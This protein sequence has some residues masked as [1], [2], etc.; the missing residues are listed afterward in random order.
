MSARVLVNATTLVVGGGIQVGASFIEHLVVHGHPG[1][2]F[3]CV[4]SRPL[5]AALAPAARTD[6]RVRAT[7]VSPAR[8][9]GGRRT[10]ALLT[11]LEAAWR[12]DL[13][14]SIGFP[15]Y[16]RFSTP[17]VG[18]YTNP[19]ALTP[20]PLAWSLIPCRERGPR[21]LKTWYRMRWA[22]RAAYVETQTEAART[23]IVE[24]LGVPRARTLVVPNAPNP[25]FLRTAPAVPPSGTG[26]HRVLC[27]A[28]PYRHKHLAF[29]PRVARALRDRH[30]A[31]DCLFV[32]TLPR[33]SHILA[34]VEQVARSL[35]VTSMIENVGPLGLD[36]C[37]TEYA[38]AAVVFQPTL[39]EVFSATYL[40]AMA[41]ARP[42]VTSDLPFA[43]EV[44]ADAAR[45]HAPLSASE[46][47]A[48]L[49]EV[50]T[51]PTVRNDLV[52]S[53]RQRLARF[54][55][56]E[57]RHRMVLDWLSRLA[58]PTADRGRRAGA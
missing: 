53:G 7:E 47:A 10:R 42:I 4:V 21:W 9:V 11:S 49:A 22:R 34:E 19:W 50:V 57:A 27:L 6:A 25:R 8:V 20:N 13:V 48:A 38:R 15:S 5:A 32:L 23:G 39:L 58:V 46:A 2:E 12:P 26:P 16:V 14:Y 43:R 45:Y 35:G 44:C 40:E 36:E 24:R 17:E 31:A 29:V 33:Q 52:E 18:R 41:M 1:L 37:V 28:A 55:A 3:L 51:D 54:P 56:P 30:A